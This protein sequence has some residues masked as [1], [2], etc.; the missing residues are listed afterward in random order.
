MLWTVA[1]NLRENQVV[2]RISGPLQDEIA[3]V[4]AEEGR[5]L[6]GYVR[7][8]LVD[9]AAARMIERNEDAPISQR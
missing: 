9:I 2:I 3:A 6:A 8:V 4:A 7:R 1:K 5:T